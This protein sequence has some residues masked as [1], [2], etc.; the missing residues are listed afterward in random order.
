MLT[1]KGFRAA[2]REVG[3]DAW[4][5]VGYDV[6]NFQVLQDREQPNIC[7]WSAWLLDHLEDVSEAYEVRS[8]R[9]GVMAELFALPHFAVKD[10]DE[11]FTVGIRDGALYLYAAN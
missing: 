8:F 3:P 4:V 2:L 5:Y 1:V 7:A 11:I 10:L 6:G 9:F